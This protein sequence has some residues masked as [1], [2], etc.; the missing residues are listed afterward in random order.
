MKD[1]TYITIHEGPSKF[2]D[3][4]CLFGGYVYAIQKIL[5]KTTRM[6][7]T[8]VSLTTLKTRKHFHYSINYSKLEDWSNLID[9]GGRMTQIEFPSDACSLPDPLT[10][11]QWIIGTSSDSYIVSKIEKLV[12]TAP[13]NEK[14]HYFG[15]SVINIPQH[16]A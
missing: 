9:T 7:Q 8:F 1:M 15:I 3:E 4:L 11:C 6:F 2:S 13:N 10:F 14:C 12:H 16:I 5:T